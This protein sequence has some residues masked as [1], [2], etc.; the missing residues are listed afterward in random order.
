[1]RVG[2]FGGAL[3]PVTIAHWELV[4]RASKENDT[5]KLLVSL[6]D[7]KSKGS[8]LMIRAADMQAVWD[9]FLTPHLPANVKLTMVENPIRSIYELLGEASEMNLNDE[10]TVYSDPEDILA[11]FPIDKQKKYFGNLVKRGRVRFVGI[12]RVGEMNVSATQ[13]REFLQRGM[14]DA[15]IQLMP[16]NVDREGIWDYLLLKCF[17]RETE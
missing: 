12:E 16:E 8:G 11:R 1:M 17:V 3:K 9:R 13:A 5:V 7:R 4:Q 6:A 10:F 15:F 14:R 2:V